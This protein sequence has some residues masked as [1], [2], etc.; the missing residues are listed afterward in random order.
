MRSSLINEVE[1]RDNI[2]EDRCLDQSEKSSMGSSLETIGDKPY[3]K[4][5]VRK[6]Y[7]KRLKETGEEG[8]GVGEGD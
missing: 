1:A 3:G 8:R 4:S 2:E 7:S 6:I 5:H